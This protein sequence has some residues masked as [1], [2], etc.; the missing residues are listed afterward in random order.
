MGP[1]VL[2]DVRDELVDIYQSFFGRIYAY[3]AR[4]LYRSD[5]AEDAAGVCFLKLV[6]QY[7]KLRGKSYIELRN[8]LY[9]VASNA[10]AKILR[11]EKRVR[12]I[13]AELSKDMS[14]VRAPDDAMLDWPAAYAA[15]GELS[16][17]ERDIL[18]LRFYEDLETRAI[19]EILGIRHVTVRVRLSRAVKKLKR[20][21]GSDLDGLQQT[22]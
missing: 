14:V 21:L 12:L 1:S 19:A 20:Q 11:D 10:V 22:A 16:Q 8:W 3:C 15:L 5:L 9:G 7:E 4:R 13:Q 18:I 17:Q 2:D 6:E